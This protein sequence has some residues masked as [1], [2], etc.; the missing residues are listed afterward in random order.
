M[1]TLA[2]VRDTQSEQRNAPTGI[3]SK[4]FAAKAMWVDDL[5]CSSSE[6]EFKK[7]V[8]QLKENGVDIDKQSP[9]QKFVGLDFHITYLRH[10][11]QDGKPVLISDNINRLYEYKDGEMT[12]PRVEFHDEK[13]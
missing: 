5:L 6:T 12:T 4:T 9:V 3:K 8:D 2:Y 10:N 13:E 7:V 1:R 11:K